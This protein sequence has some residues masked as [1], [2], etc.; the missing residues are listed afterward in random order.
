V[1]KDNHARN[2]RGNNGHADPALLLDSIN[3]TIIDLLLV[4][5]QITQVELAKKLAMSQS[6][7]AVRLEKL[8][9]SGLVETSIGL[10][11]SRLGLRMG[12][13]DVATGK[14]DNV[15]EWATKCPLFVNSTL[16]IGGNNVSLFM[17]SEDMEMFQYIV[18]HHGRKIRGVTNL[19][20]NPILQ[21]SKDNFV[22]LQ[23]DVPKRESPPCG[24]LP[25]CPKCPANPNYEGKIWLNGRSNK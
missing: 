19:S 9:T 21:W 14:V 3:R 25:F 17:V 8:R 11:L 2:Q 4:H 24:L 5:P 12:R 13:I 18:E 7:I 1:S 6:S 20:F 10:D 16:G 22:P 15:L 23:L